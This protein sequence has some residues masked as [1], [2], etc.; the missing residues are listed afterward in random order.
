MN[1]SLATI[2]LGSW[3][4]RT[5]P[6][7]PIR[8]LRWIG[9]IAVSATRSPSGSKIAAEQSIRSVIFGEK[10]DLMSVAI[11]SSQVEASRY[12]IT[13]VAIRS[14]ANARSSSSLGS[15]QSC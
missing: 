7:R 12:A 4:L 15:Q 14:R 5:F 1:T 3:R 13:S 2:A 8:E 11:I 9:P 10:A 6:T